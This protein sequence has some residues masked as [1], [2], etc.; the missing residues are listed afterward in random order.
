MHAMPP[1]TH[2]RSTHL[3]RTHLLICAAHICAISKAQGC[4]EIKIL[5]P[6]FIGW[7]RRYGGP[8]YGETWEQINTDVDKFLCD[9][10]G[11]ESDEE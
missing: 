3:R 7:V 1:C 10:S 6:N 11:E 4:D 8:F 2:L 5:D 9:I